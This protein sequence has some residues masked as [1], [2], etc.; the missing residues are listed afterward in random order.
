MALKKFKP[1]TAG[2]RWRIG[3]AFAEVTT[4]VPEKSLV[5][6]KKRS[7]GRNTSGHLTMRYIGGG[8]KKKYRIIDFKRN[9]KE[10]EATVKTVEY[11][12]NRTSFIALVAHSDGEPRRVCRS[13]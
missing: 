4:N 3:N 6:T 5:E 9:K 7:G 10:L 12:P 1:V 8:H 11:D 13:E 2:T